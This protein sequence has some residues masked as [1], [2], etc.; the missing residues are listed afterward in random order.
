ML[1]RSVKNGT[2]AIYS[3]SSCTDG[4]TVDDTNILTNTGNTGLRYD[5]TGMQFI[6]NWQT[7]KPPAKCYMATMTSNDGTSLSAYF[8]TK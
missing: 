2:V 1:F 5:T 4:Y 3:L 7:P 6:Q 8:K